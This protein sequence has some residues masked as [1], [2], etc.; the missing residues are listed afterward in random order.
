MRVIKRIKWAGWVALILFSVVTFGTIYYFVSP[1]IEASSG[2]NHTAEVEEISE[3]ASLNIRTD[4]K[5]T[6]TYTMSISMPTFK[7]KS[8]NL[9]IKEWMEQQKSVFIEEVERNSEML[10]A[11]NL[12]H[13]TIDLKV[14]TTGELYSLL[15]TAYQ[16]VGKGKP[17]QVF[18]TFTVNRKSGQSVQLH[19]IIDLNDEASKTIRTF[20]KDQLMEWEDYVREEVLNEKLSDLDNL[21]WSISKQTL[22]I[23][24]DPYEVAAGSVGGIEMKIPL[25]AL[26]SYLHPTLL[27]NAQLEHMISIE[28]SQLDPHG[29]YIALTFDDGPSPKVTPQILKTLKQHG[30]KATF[31]MLGKQ[32]ETYPQIAAQV[33]NDGHEIANHSYSHSK[34]T[35]LTSQE[36]IKEMSEA[37]KKIEMATGIEPVL[38]RPPYGAYN[39]D[40][41]HY[42]KMNDYSMILWSV[43]SLDW[44]SRNPVAINDIVTNNVTNGSIVLMHDIHA[45]TAE[46][47]PEL[48]VTL[49]AAGYQFV[50]VS[51][52]LMLQHENGAGPHFGHVS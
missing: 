17:T 6:D 37:T 34:L 50:T 26:R 24:F 31:F 33:A 13:L 22:N 23:F 5:E 32:V 28:K 30:A 4:T 2:T 11:D 18:K 3:D 16:Y 42:A 35:K 46:A 44:K 9:P 48:L 7:S 12:A 25:Q 20:I 1:A 36:M 41:V 43:D 38:F 27:N 45:S 8:L 15:F 29:K 47:L 51:E 49:K 52:L 19:D 39:N 40:V 10:N 21:T 14:E